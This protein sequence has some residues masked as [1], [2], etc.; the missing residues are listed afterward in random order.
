MADGWANFSSNDRNQNGH[1][2]EDDDWDDFGGFE[3]A[4]PMPAELAQ[5]D[6][7][8]EA[9]PSPWAV[10]SAGG[11][12]GAAQPDL[13][14][15]PAQPPLPNMDN[16]FLNNSAPEVTANRGGS[17][18]CQGAVG[19]PP[20]ITMQAEASV[21]QAV[22]QTEADRKKS[23]LNDIDV[24]LVL[25]DNL[26]IIGS[27][28]NIGSAGVDSSSRNSNPVL[29]NPPVSQSNN[30]FL[31]NHQGSSSVE[32]AQLSG[33]VDNLQEQLSIVDREKK[34]LQQE[35]QE[36]ATRNEQLQEELA[37]EIT[38]LEEQ[39]KKYNDLELKHSG[40]I[41]DLRKAG[42]DT[43]AIMLEEYK[44][45]C[46][47]A[48][49]EQQ[50]ANEQRLKEALTKES[51]RCETLMT[52]QHERLVSL[53]EEERKR[54]EELTRTTIAELTK[55]HEEEIENVLSIQKLKTE[56]ANKKAIEMMTQTHKEYMEKLIAEEKEESAAVLENER[57]AIIEMSEKERMK[58][59]EA[60]NSALQQETDKC[61]AAIKDA[62]AEERKSQDEANKFAA[63]KTKAIMLEHL[64]EQKKADSAVRQRSLASIDLF[65]E[66]ARQQLQ[67]LLESPVQFSNENDASS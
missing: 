3:G 26:D 46:K 33:R 59:K 38:E 51:E 56:E 60:L 4:E 62:L 16:L 9:S 34:R 45:L 44:G 65:L 27:R 61:K 23:S 20:E 41:A 43:L 49:L 55:K 29:R 8:N 67:M 18:P 12:G 31:G 24:D 19:G 30:S 53:L 1:P 36:M 6:V 5:Q 28:K 47:C 21:L 32:A 17:I 2:V 39:K 35:L 63:E 22:G 7:P 58:S 25:D 13:L 52:S 42:H 64:K 15:A 48:I 11:A 40:D 54:N 57:K 37:K 50:E 10:F 66:G 14:I